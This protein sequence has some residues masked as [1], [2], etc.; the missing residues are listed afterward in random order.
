MAE[1]SLTARAER[2]PLRRTERRS[3]LADEARDERTKRERFRGQDCVRA[4]AQD[5]EHLVE[6]R[7]SLLH[8]PGLDRG[9]R[10][11]HDE[12]EALGLVRDE[13]ERAVEV[14]D[15]A[16]RIEAERTFRART[17]ACFT[18]GR[19][20]SARAASPSSLV[21]RHRLAQVVREQ[22]CDVLDPA[23][24]PRPRSSPPRP[25]ASAHAAAAG[26]VRRRRPERVRA[27]TRAPAHPRPPTCATAGRTRAARARANHR[28]PAAPSPRRPP[29]PP[30]SRRP[31]RARTRPEGDSCAPARGCRDAMR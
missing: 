24:G 20:A 5:R 6:R 21:E 26:S 1:R 15:R 18:R 3:S 8:A 2:P 30:R 4:G 7:H 22:V 17:S 14:R 31:C 16:L 29:L 19:R 11:P 25:G 10:P 13:L 28:Q 12:L 9:V 23:A 27:R